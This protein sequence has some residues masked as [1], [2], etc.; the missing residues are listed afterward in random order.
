[1]KLPQLHRHSKTC[2]KYKNEACRF[3]FGK[4]FS[5]QTIVVKPLRSDLPENVKDLVLIKRKEILN[6]VKD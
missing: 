3:H 4:L 2:L 6:K 5:K 1:M